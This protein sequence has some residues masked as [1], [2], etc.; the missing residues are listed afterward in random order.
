[1]TNV[2][3][4]PTSNTT[5]AVPQ[6]WFEAP[7]ECSYDFFPTFRRVSVAL[8]S[9]L[10]RT[11][12]ASYFADVSRY[13]NTLLAYPVLVYA[14]SKP[15]P[16]KYRTEYTYDVLKPEHM[17]RVFRGLAPRLIILLMD[18]CEQLRAAGRE[19]LLKIYTPNNAQNIIDTVRRR[20]KCR[21][22]LE[23]LL[24]NDFLLLNQLFAFGGSANLPAKA[25]ERKAVVFNKTW[26]ARLRKL[27]SVHD[28][29]AISGDLLAAATEA[30]VTPDT[31][32]AEAAVIFEEP[33]LKAA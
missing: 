17:N 11:V 16:G 5:P 23:G 24:V 10:R 15:F 3:E 6:A 22:R 19:D 13:S 8:Q 26:A 14:A 2:I 27:Y 31:E 4:F 32:P 1:M 28:F 33:L 25:R 30:L 18:V 7:D 20:A 29:S 12:P 9:A 21:H